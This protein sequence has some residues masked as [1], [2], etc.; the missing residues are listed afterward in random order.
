MPPIAK[1][2][3][4]LTLDSKKFNKGIGAAQCARD[5]GRERIALR[6]SG[7]RAFYSTATDA[8]S[9]PARQAFHTEDLQ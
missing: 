5:M 3:S 1:L 2:K 4:E 8:I 6:T 7:D 9:M